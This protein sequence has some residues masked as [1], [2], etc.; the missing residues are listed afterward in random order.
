MKAELHFGLSPSDHSVVLDGVDVSNGIHALELRASVHKRTELTLHLPILDQGR[1][2]GEV[3]AL[4]PNATHDLL[5]CLGWTP[6]EV[7]P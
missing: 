3:R 7:S 4:I 2:D 5:V 6:P 1:A